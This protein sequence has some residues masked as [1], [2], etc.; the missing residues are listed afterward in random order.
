MT[1]VFTI[2][3]V[4]QF[5]YLLTAVQAIFFMGECSFDRDCGF[6]T[7]RNWLFDCKASVVIFE[8]M[9]WFPLSFGAVIFYRS[10]VLMIIHAILVFIT[11][12]QKSIDEVISYFFIIS[13]KYPNLIF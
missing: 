3:S 13:L 5:Y 7:V 12:L 1:L 2:F 11:I 9:T 4:P 10:L 6:Y 8:F